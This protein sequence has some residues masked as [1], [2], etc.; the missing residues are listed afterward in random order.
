MAFLLLMEDSIKS[1]DTTQ[2]TERKRGSRDR[3]T[4]KKIAYVRAVRE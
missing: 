4:D 2:V 3:R 1:W